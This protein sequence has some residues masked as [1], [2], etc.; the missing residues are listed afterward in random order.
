MAHTSI[1]R[2]PSAAI[3]GTAIAVG[4]GAF[5]VAVL[6]S[7]FAAFLGA[8]CD[9]PASLPYVLL[10]VGAA[11]LLALLGRNRLGARALL[12]PSLTLLGVFPLF[13]LAMLYQLGQPLVSSHF[14]CGTG[15]IG[16]FMLAPFV[17][18]GS[19]FVSLLVAAF[20][21]RQ[22]SAV[23]DRAVRLGAG[24]TVAV[25]LVLGVASACHARG[26]V[27][28]ERYV[29]SLPVAARLPP[30]PEL[31]AKMDD[32][33]DTSAVVAGVT[34]ARSL[35]R[36]DG[37]YSS[38]RGTVNG[39]ALERFGACEGLEVR[40]D[41]R[42]D[43][44]VF[45]SVPEGKTEPSPWPL[46]AYRISEARAIDIGVSEVA[47]VVS[48]PR[49]WIVLELL[50]SGI[51][52]ALL[53]LSAWRVRSLSRRERG[54]A[55]A[56]HEGGGWLAFDA[57][58]G[59]GDGAHEG[60]SRVHVPSAEPLPVG[61]VVVR[62]GALGPGGYRGIA[63]P[64]VQS[65]REGT[66]DDLARKTRDVATAWSALAWLAVALGLAPLLAAVFAGIAL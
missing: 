21:T 56:R 47:P 52:A 41:P 23:L 36:K 45:L 7:A 28:P 32:G 34:V 44:L 12:L 3:T 59:A 50:A 4:V 10:L 65:V 39:A 51:A 26:R 11:P 61:P 49:G 40:R 37:S 2:E 63:A 20:V 46:F 64:D 17:L 6:G 53:V 19:L 58:P 13:Q 30:V 54:L 35:L 66:T 1:A 22:R 25:G 9:I 16:L 57:T 24:L 38:C 43:I 60:A 27:S 62:L 42:G 5:F 31:L 55:E 8:S 33:P 48:A 29:A 15:E 18:A 14:R